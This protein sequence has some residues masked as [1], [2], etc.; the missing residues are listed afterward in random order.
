MDNMLQFNNKFPYGNN[1]ST[2]N[3]LINNNPIKII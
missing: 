2:N 1:N 3:N